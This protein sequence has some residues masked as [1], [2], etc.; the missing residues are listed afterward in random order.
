MSKLIDQ[1]KRRLQ[2][3]F[4]P[5]NEGGSWMTLAEGREQPIRLGVIDSY[6]V[7]RVAPHFN[8]KGNI[9]RVEF[10][11]LFKVLATLQLFVRRREVDRLQFATAP[12]SG[13]PPVQ[14]LVQL[15]FVQLR[16]QR[17]A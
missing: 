5:F 4:D 15:S 3:L 8:A 10:W 1:E 17:P 13:R 12:R 11:L 6:T 2:A 16:R 9:T 7:T 14:T